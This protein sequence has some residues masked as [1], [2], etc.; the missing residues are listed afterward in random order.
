[1][2]EW[3]PHK[4]RSQ[5]CEQN[6]ID[7]NKKYNVK[8]KEVLVSTIIK[9]IIQRQTYMKDDAELSKKFESIS[10]VPTPIDVCPS[11]ASDGNWKSKVNKEESKQVKLS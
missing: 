6:V 5:L 7:M 2:K 11:K 3:Y 1:M 8:A 4:I 9:V 10:I